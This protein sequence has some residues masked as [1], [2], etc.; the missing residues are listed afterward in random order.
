MHNMEL[1]GSFANRAFALERAACAIFGIPTFGVHMT[2]ETS[3][4]LT[5]HEL[6]LDS[7]YE[8]EGEKMKIWVPKRAKTKAT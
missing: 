8:G 2:G 3:F 7:G 6:I 4:V 1:S 5:G